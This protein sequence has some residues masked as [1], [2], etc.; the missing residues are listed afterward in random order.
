[1]DELLKRVKAKVKMDL[2][3]AIDFLE[4]KR[5]SMAIMS[6]EKA[7]GRMSVVNDDESKYQIL[8]H[9]MVAYH[10]SETPGRHE[11][12]LE[13]YRELSRLK[14]IDYQFHP[15]AM[16]LRGI[17]LVRWGRFEEGIEVFTQLSHWTRGRAIYQTWA[18]LSEI[19]LLQHCVTSK[20][21]IN[22]AK[23]YAFKLL[24]ECVRKP[25]LRKEKMWALHQLGQIFVMEKQYHQALPYLRESLDMADLPHDRFGVYLE[26]AETFL[27]LQQ[28][29][30]G[31]QYLKEAEGFFQ[32]QGDDAGLARALHLKGRYLIMEG[33]M[34]Q[35]EELFAEAV[36][37]YYKTENWGKY[38]LLL[39]EMHQTMAKEGEEEALLRDDLVWL[40]QSHM[41]EEIHF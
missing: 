16:R 13:C 15:E 41:L 4:E 35:G 7:V 6:L 26:M 33:Q 34:E 22:L 21:S 8:Y 37:L 31:L 5:W 32:R 25:H 3:Q 39:Q 2:Q 40:M 29:S 14:V 11:R 19:Y 10:Y 12:V 17:A 30:R 20:K 28:V 38:L 23:H 27:G 24:D 18:Y 9:L 1:M 36:Q